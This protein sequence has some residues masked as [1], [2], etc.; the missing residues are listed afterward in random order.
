[1]INRGSL[2][3]LVPVV[4]ILGA[5]WFLVLSPTRGEVKATEIELLQATTRRDAAA[6]TAAT[7]ERA[8]RDYPRDYA[9]VVSLA[10]A[11]PPDEDIAA[12]VRG[13][14]SIARANKLDVRTIALSGAVAEEPAPQAAGPAA[15]SAG[16][17]EGAAPAK[18]DGATATGAAAGTNAPAGDGAGAVAQAPAGAAVGSAGLLTMPFTFTAE[19]GYLSL[20]RFLK[21]LHARAGHVNGQIRVDGRLLTI[22]GYSFVAG[23][24]GFPQLAALVSATA[25]LEP[26][27]GGVIAHSTRRRPATAT[28]APAAAQAAA[29]AAG[30]AG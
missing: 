11:V 22:D 27:P 17:G 26:D 15:G 28:P 9:S 21:A 7:A 8:R 25:Y 4:L 5:F 20:Q 18:T 6:V 29:P 12:L 3:G 30:A 16:G 1:M 10:E 14:D 13:L 24:K 23:R 19:G 2:L